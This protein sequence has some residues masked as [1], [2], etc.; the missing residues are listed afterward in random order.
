MKVKETL[1]YIIEKG[2]LEDMYKLNDMLNDLICDLKEKHPKMYHEYKK[3]LYEI[4]YGRV[5][6]EEKAKE[7]VNHMLP[8]GEHYDMEKAKEIKENY[9]IRH[10]VNDIYLV[11]NSLYNDYHELLDENNEMYAKMTKLWLNDA[12]GIEDK[13]YEYFCMIPKED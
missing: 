4:A 13:V 3:E 8:Y 9:G 7:I 12:D 5:I 10:S 6:L 1:K 2:R 11:I